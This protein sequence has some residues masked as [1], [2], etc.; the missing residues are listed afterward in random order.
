MRESNLGN[1]V[2]GHVPPIVRPTSGSCSASLSSFEHCFHT[3]FHPSNIEYG[4]GWGFP[5]ESRIRDD[6]N[7]AMFVAF[8]PLTALNMRTILFSKTV[9]LSRAKA[10]WISEVEIRKEPLK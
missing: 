1:V 9:C 8:N 5:K 7:L 2:G 6:K 10:L 4:V 3:S